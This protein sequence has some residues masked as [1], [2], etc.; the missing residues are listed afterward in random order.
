MFIT[1]LIY[2]YLVRLTLILVLQGKYN[3]VLYKYIDEMFGAV[4]CL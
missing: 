1:Y 4:V 3:F 2:N